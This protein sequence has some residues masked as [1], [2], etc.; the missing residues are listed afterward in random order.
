MTSSRDSYPWSERQPAEHQPAERQLRQE[1]IV[2][3]LSAKAQSVLGSVSV[4]ALILDDVD[5]CLL[6]G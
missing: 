2:L 4:P 5:S 6:G 3:G 1:R